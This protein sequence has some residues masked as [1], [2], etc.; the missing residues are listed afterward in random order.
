MGLS[1][2]CV[3][4]CVCVCA[5]MCV[6][7][8]CAAP[9]VAVVTPIV[10]G[11]QTANGNVE[12]KVVCFYRRR[13][14]SSTLIALADKH[15]SEWPT[16]TQPVNTR[17]QKHGNQDFWQP[18]AVLFH[19]KVVVPSHPIKL[20]FPELENTTVIF[21]GLSAHQIF[22]Q[23]TAQNWIEFVHCCWAERNRPISSP[24]FWYAWLQ[25]AFDLLDVSIWRHLRV[26]VCVCV[27]VCVSMH[28]AF[29]S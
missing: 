22:F 3:C 27:C 5:R 26:C 21:I 7:A 6:G 10:S 15:A 8:L 1:S 20:D 29:I 13:D 14:I 4:V 23:G 17:H 24:S 19:C 18:S 2:V 16:V 12:A 9:L 28:I 11:L 25:T